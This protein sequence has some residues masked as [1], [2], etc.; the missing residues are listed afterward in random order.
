MHMA[1]IS[2]L[3]N[4]VA[5]MWSDNHKSDQDSRLMG[6]AIAIGVVL[7]TVLVIFSLNAHTPSTTIPIMQRPVMTAELVK[8][9][10]PTPPPPPPK[11]TPKIQK[12]VSRRPVISPQKP[13]PPMPMPQAVPSIPVA[14]TSSQTA[15][16]VATP[17]TEAHV[18][19]P[20]SATQR[21]TP[22]AIGVICPVQ[23]HPEMPGIAESENISGS[24][25]ARATI[26][27]GKVVRVDILKSNP[28]GVFDQAVRDAMLHYRCESNVDGDVVAEQTFSFDFSD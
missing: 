12:I 11:I 22:I 25:T 8:Q 28:K 20:V 17:A 4:T 1:P 3:E 14:K 19:S 18:A 5:F 26:N 9:V 7:E 15:P 2:S 21:S 27:H 16:A 13:Q 23:T 10:T 6:R 24:V